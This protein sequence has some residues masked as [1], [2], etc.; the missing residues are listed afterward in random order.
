MP[1]PLD[2]RITYLNKASRKEVTFQVARSTDYFCKV[3]AQQ[4]V[5]KPACDLWWN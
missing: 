3:F 1:S 2:Y 5:L 4:L